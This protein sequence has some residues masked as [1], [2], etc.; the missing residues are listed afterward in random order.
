MAA[1]VRLVLRG[2]PLLRGSHVLLAIAV[3]ALAGPA[4]LADGSGPG[5]V[6]LAGPGAALPVPSRASELP[7]LDVPGRHA[8]AVAAAR[9]PELASAL[10]ARLG[11]SYQD[12]GSYLLLSD[13]VCRVRLYPNSY[14]IALDGEDRTLRG[15]LARGPQGVTLPG[16]A[17]AIVEGHIQRVR[18][19][20]LAP[21]PAPKAAT[22]LA[23]KA[24]TPPKARPAPL[25]RPMYGPASSA[26]GA[27]SQVKPDPSWMVASTA[28]TWKWI[29]LHHS[30]DTRGN[31]EKYHQG[32][33]GQG[34]EH[35]CGY[36]F[37]IGNGSLSGDGEVEVSQRWLRQLHGA[38]AK[39][40]DNL[41]NEQGIGICLVGDF[42]KGSARP[43]AAQMR[44]LVR[45]T[46][47]LMDRY[48]IAP[49]GVR[50]H[51]HCKPTCCPG[52]NFPWGE[53]RSKLR[54]PAPVAGATPTPGAVPSPG[55]GPSATASTSPS[56]TP[57]LAL[58]LPAA[59]LASA[60]P[61]A[62]AAPEGPALGEPPAGLPSAGFPPPAR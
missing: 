58:R 38:H 11:L 28:R 8:G 15:Y 17:A 47:W 42:E 61:A 62:S 21:P 12:A 30:D 3:A 59:P 54:A 14:R 55:A 52:K 53:L 60:A 50:G 37:V 27:A 1:C 39:T 4:A 46:Q 43:S 45:L 22:V 2:S 6:A 13:G 35:G 25:L 19:Q 48:G 20:R 44:A 9:A 41:F 24:L 51:C 23:P 10:A 26:S 40:P 29:V 33:L 5:A 49:A 16:P 36:H 18:A 34:W 57:A 56:A 32:H 7:G 31:L